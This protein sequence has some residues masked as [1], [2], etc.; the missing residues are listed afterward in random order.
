MI[1]EFEIKD[2][3]RIE[4]AAGES[5]GIH[6]ILFFSTILNVRSVGF[7]IEGTYVSIAEEFI[8]ETTPAEIAKYKIQEIFLLTKK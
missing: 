6:Q 3:V 7:K 5:T 2:I 8:R 1:K 4:N